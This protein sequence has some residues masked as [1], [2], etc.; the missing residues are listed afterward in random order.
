MTALLGINPCPSEQRCTGA[1]AFRF[2]LYSD[3]QTPVPRAAS[4]SMS[5]VTPPSGTKTTVDST[6]RPR[7]LPYAPYTAGSHLYSAILNPS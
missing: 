1:P 5:R 7:Y 3:R 6:Y 4:P 2:A